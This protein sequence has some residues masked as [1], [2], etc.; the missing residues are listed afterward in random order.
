MKA[1]DMLN[2]LVV[3]ATIICGTLAAINAIRRHRKE[4]D[5]HREPVVDIIYGEVLEVTADPGSGLSCMAI[6]D[7]KGNI[8]YGFSGRSVKEL[9]TLYKGA[10]MTQVVVTGTRK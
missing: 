4:K 6:R 5:V 3:A 1:L 8:V 7:R 2:G 10:G 9:E